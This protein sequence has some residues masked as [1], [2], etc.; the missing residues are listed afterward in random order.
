VGKVCK[1]RLRMHGQTL[2]EVLVAMVVLGV[3]L[4]SVL[5]AFSVCSLA[6]GVIR[7]E[8]IARSWAAGK[9]G[10]LRTNPALLTSDESGDLGKEYPGFTWRRQVRETPEHGVLSTSIEVKWKNR[11]VERSYSLVTLIRTPQV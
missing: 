1:A 5:E 2:V 3:G 10:E 4:V 7:S 11:G 6:V 8:G 9:M